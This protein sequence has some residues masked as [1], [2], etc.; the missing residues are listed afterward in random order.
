MSLKWEYRGKMRPPF[1]EEPAAGQESIW[2]YPRPPQ[3]R[4]CDRT[5]VVSANGRQIARSRESYRVME[6]AGP[7]CFYLSEQAVDWTQLTQTS[8]RSFCEWKGVAVYWRL[9]SDT[10]RDPVGWSYTDLPPSFEMLRG[11]ISFY[12][13]RIDCYVDEEKVRPQPGNFYGGWITNDVVGPFKGE[14]GTENW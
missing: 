6:T 10:K 4:R 1:A 8:G 13:G 12:P 7:P 5:V 11:H 2:D 9:N 3:V 14:P